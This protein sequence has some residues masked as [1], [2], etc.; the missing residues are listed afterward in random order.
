MSVRISTD[1]FD[2]DKRI[3]NLERQIMVMIGQIAARDAAIAQL[4]KEMVSLQADAGMTFIEQFPQMLDEI[5]TKV[6]SSITEADEQKVTE[7]L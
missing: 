3:T 2:R 6:L 4:L 5:D 7:Y 1:E